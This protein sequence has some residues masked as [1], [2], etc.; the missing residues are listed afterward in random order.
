VSTEERTMGQ[1]LVVANQTL[2]GAELDRAIQDRI[3]RGDSQFFIVVPMTAPKHE[4]DAWGRGFSAYEGMS[5]A[6]IEQTRTA[7][8]EDARRHEA[9]VDEARRRAQH[10][11]DQMIDKIQAAGGEADGTVGDADPA[12][13]VKDV[14]RD[15]SFDE[16][17]L[18]TLPSGISRWIRMDL[19]SRVA[20][21]TKAPVITVEAEG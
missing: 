13:A 17:I 2:G 14:L 9:L 7:I 5:R 20:R 16:V 18:S 1:Y 19:P 3:E 21:M 4:T 12:V 6:Q 8:E 15:Q 10:R 11:M